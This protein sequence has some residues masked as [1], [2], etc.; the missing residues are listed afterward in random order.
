MRFDY[1]ICDRPS[2]D[3][4]CMNTHFKRRRFMYTT[5]EWNNTSR[6][7]TNSEIIYFGDLE[8][9][10]EGNGYVVSIPRLLAAIKVIREVTVANSITPRNAVGNKWWIRDS[11]LFVKHKVP[12]S[13]NIQ[14][15]DITDEVYETYMSSLLDEF[16]EPL[17]TKRPKPIRLC[18]ISFLIIGML[19]YASTPFN[20]LALMFM[21]SGIA[22][23]FVGKWLGRFYDNISRHII[24]FNFTTA[25]LIMEKKCKLIQTIAE[26]YV[27][28][29]KGNHSDIEAY[30]K[31]HDLNSKSLVEL[32]AMSA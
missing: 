7:V 22:L 14:Y 25:P 26:D 15:T 27:F 13:R 30:I 1:G 32:L 9:R 19:L 20:L 28:E 6:T 23:F 3:D 31:K 10:I 2:P 17:S 18:T 8:K 21:W 11:T 29:N 4:D 12:T 16:V 24:S 5:T